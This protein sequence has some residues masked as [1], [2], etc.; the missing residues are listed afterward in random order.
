MSSSSDILPLKQ[1][2]AHFPNIGPVRLQLMRQAGIRQ[3]DDIE[4]NPPPPLNNWSY[5]WEDIYNAAVDA[6]EAFANGN[7]QFFTQNLK[8]SDRWR[9]LHLKLSQTT[10][11]DIETSGLESLDNYI[12]TIVAFDGQKLHTFVKN[13]N[14]E[15]FPDFL[16]TLKFIVTYNGSTFDL[17]KIMRE[18]NLPNIPVPHVDLRWLCHNCFLDGGLKNIEKTLNIKRPEDIRGTDGNDA[19]VP[20]VFLQRVER[21]GCRLLPLYRRPVRCGKKAEARKRQRERSGKRKICL[22]RLPPPSGLRRRRVQASAADPLEKSLRQQ[23]VSQRLRKAAGRRGGER[24]CVMIYKAPP[25]LSDSPFEW[26]IYA[27]FTFWNS[28][29]RL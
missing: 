29:S 24:A 27:V 19:E 17:P 1:A 22:P 4:P 6:R 16:L 25:F 13:E 12:T 20:L 21:R 26:K 18:F 28:G 11:I 3:W 9:L 5:F 8:P 14:L 10:F 2:F 7:L 15:D 23:R